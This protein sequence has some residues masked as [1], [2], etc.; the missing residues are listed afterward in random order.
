[1]NI[2][3]TVADL[4]ST[5]HLLP[6]Y[7]KVD[8]KADIRYVKAPGE[9]GRRN[10]DLDGAIPEQLYPSVSFVGR[11]LA[12][13][14]L[15]FAA[16]FVQLGAD[17]LSKIFGVHEDHGLVLAGMFEEV[18]N[19]V[20]FSLGCHL[21]LELVDVAELELHV[22]QSD[23]RGLANEGAD[24][25]GDLDWVCSTEEHKLDLR[26]KSFQALVVD[27]L[28]SCI[29]L[30]FTE[31]E[32]GFVNNDAPNILQVNSLL[33][34]KRVLQLADRTG[35]HMLRSIPVVLCQVSYGDISILIDFSVDIGYLDCQFP[36]MA[37]NQHLWLLNG[38]VNSQ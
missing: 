24:S 6:R 35:D 13:D 36:H 31:E 37:Q 23:L 29:I 8:H 12:K 11:S 21:L 10:Q 4:L 5:V 14:Q 9:H 22:F 2:S 1:M 25:V 20:N 30:T 27:L 28:K 15:T 3:L 17:D 34:L 26:E 33:T 7:V 38:R 18:V 19:E 32:V 16:H